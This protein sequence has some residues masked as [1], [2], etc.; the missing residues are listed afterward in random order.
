MT[1]DLSDKTATLLH[2]L[3]KVD[4]T[5]SPMPNPTEANKCCSEIFHRRQ[6]YLRGEGIPWV[7]GGSAEVR[8]HGAQVLHSLH[9][10][11]LVILPKIRGQHRR[12]GLT[13]RGDDMGRSLLGYWRASDCWHLLQG[14]TDAVAD[15]RG[16][17]PTGPGIWLLE[18]Q[19]KQAIDDSIEKLRAMILPLHVRGLVRVGI[20]TLGKLYYTVSKEGER[21]AAGDP[22]EP[23]DDVTRD[24]RAIPIYWSAYN[25]FAREREGW[26]P[27]SENE[28]YIPFPAMR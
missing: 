28:V 18:R 25:A 4:S 2:I 17:G 27:A 6:A 5:F 7:I 3:A 9:Q 16:V 12:V 8:Q 10:A 13:P 20:D 26:T 24:E 23:Q 1:G 11:G 21:A 15:R 22:P 14:M 19:I